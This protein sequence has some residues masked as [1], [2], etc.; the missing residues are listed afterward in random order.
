[1]ELVSKLREVVYK[2]PA[3]DI[4]ALR[5]S[6][7][8]GL[9]LDSKVVEGEAEQPLARHL[10]KVLDSPAWQVRALAAAKLAQALG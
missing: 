3:E 10:E 4:S 8:I 6:L 5:A 1:M 2:E 7:E 9:A